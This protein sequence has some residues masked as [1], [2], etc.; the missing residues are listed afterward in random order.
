MDSLQTFI[1]SHPG[2]I[3]AFCIFFI[4]GTEDCGQSKS[5]PNY[6]FHRKKTFQ[7]ASS[8]YNE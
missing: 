4:F 3:F 2:F 7:I 1:Q 6:I 5:Y 8:K